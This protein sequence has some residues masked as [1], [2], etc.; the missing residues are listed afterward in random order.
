M[1]K[2]RQMQF[3]DKTAYVQGLRYRWDP[4]LSRKPLPRFPH[5]MPPCWEHSLLISERFVWVKNGRLHIVNI[6]RRSNH[7]HHQYWICIVCHL[8]PGL[9]SGVIECVS[10]STLLNCGGDWFKITILYIVG[11]RPKNKGTKYFGQ[12]ISKSRIVEGSFESILKVHKLS[13]CDY[14]SCEI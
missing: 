3:R 8:N 14:V 6:E 1:R 13:I 7:W 5:F 4:L 11:Q 2:S 12:K 9:F 10:A